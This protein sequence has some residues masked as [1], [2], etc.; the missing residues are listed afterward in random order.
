[1]VINI[2]AKHLY[3]ISVRFKINRKL[4]KL[5]ALI[6]F[7]ET[8]ILLKKLAGIHTIESIMDILSVSKKKAIYYVYRLRK[9]GY[10]KTRAASNKIRIYYINKKNRFGG[11]SYYEIINSH[12]PFKL[13]ESSFYKIY[14]RESSLEETLVYAI[15]TKEIRVITAALGLFKSIN[16]WTLLG[17]LARKNH[18]ERSVGAL[19]DVARKIMKTR[20]MSS[21]LR[22]NLLP[23]K[24][25]KFAEVIEGFKSKD[26]KDIEE[27]WK[28]RIPLN[29]ADLEDY[30]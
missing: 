15:K 7:M 17:E 22:N 18:I 3:N 20:R 4:Y 11:K 9:Q 23:G 16:N 13:A 6:F 21:T 10:V 14:G 19:Y 27:E 26:F 24:S 1:M 25:A 29:K 5:K 30:K 8:K 28:I 2:K 12:S